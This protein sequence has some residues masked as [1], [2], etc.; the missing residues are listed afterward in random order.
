M[1][2]RLLLVSAVAV[3]VGC[4]SI[5]NRDSATIAQVSGTLSGS[6]PSGARVALVWAGKNNTW[7]VSHE[8]PIVAGAYSLDLTSAPSDDL[9]FSPSDGNNARPPDTTVT[10]PDQG[11]SS[12]S[13]DSTGSVPKTG[14][15]GKQLHTNDVVSGSAGAP[16]LSAAVAAFV[17][18]VDGNGN[19]RLDLSGP[20]AETPDQIVGGSSELML[21]YM[22]DGSNL[23]FEKLRDKAG[24]APTRGYDLFLT[25]KS[26]WVGLNLADLT[27]GTN[28]MPSNVCGIGSITTGSDIGF[29]SPDQ[30]VPMTGGSSGTGGTTSTGFAWASGNSKAPSLEHGPYPSPGDPNLQCSPDGRY[31]SYDSCRS[32]SS[33]P[34][35][36]CGYEHP[37]PCDSYGAQ[38]GSS[39]AVPDGWPC[40]ATTTNGS[41]DGG[42]FDAGVSDAGF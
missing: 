32:K 34:A 17:I 27:L 38:L 33:T 31:W 28:R 5:S 35:G 2:R 18:Y 29:A 25:D 39:Q 14:G 20:N 12:G 41:S 24:Q 37:V 23:D 30:P 6:V 1:S 16:P 21:V 10:A 36:L 42:T 3:A 19:G 40:N 7:V 22:R 13:G 4:G 26:R 15:S 8:A 11:S 9:F